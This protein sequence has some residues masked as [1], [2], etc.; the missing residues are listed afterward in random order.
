[1]KCPVCGYEDYNGGKCPSCGTNATNLLRLSE[2]PDAYY[3]KA[4]ELI[5]KDHIE[6]AKE[7]LI[8]TIRLNPDDVDA[9]ILLGKVCAEAGDYERAVVYWNKALRLDEN[10]TEEIKADIGKVEALKKTL[11]E[12]KPSEVKENLEE[13]LRETVRTETRKGFIKWSAYTG[14]ILMLIII[15]DSYLSFRLYLIPAKEQSVTAEKNREFFASEIRKL[16]K[17]I[18]NKEILT[19]EFSKLSEEIKEII[20]LEIKKLVLNDVSIKEKEIFTSEVRV[21]LKLHEISN[22]VIEEREGTVYLKGKVPTLWDK[23]KIEKAVKEVN[24]SVGIDMR[25][26]EV[27]YPNGYY[28]R[29]KKG[30]NLWLIAEKLL[31]DGKKFSKILS[32]NE[33]TLKDPSNL[34]LGEKL[35]IPE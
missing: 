20:P 3:N 14:V 1:M 35:L 30:D 29:A 17:E 9:L 7:A 12:E 33:K 23:Q 8:A 2:I 25:G 18:K 21:I 6:E 32:V 15:L 28:Y 13:R 31:G 11:E 24:M 10:R 34:I 26:I 5:K 22:I 4:V 16:S 27:T 19:S